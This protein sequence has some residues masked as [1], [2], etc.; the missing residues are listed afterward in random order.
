MYSRPFETLSQNK[1]V[2]GFSFLNLVNPDAIAL[3]MAP[4]IGHVE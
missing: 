2:S 4:G 1:Y 3:A